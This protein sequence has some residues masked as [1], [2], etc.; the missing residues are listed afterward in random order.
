MRPTGQVIEGRYRVVRWVDKGGIGEVYEVEHLH[1]QRRCAFKEMLSHKV[2]EE[3][4]RARFARE[5][6][7]SSRVVHENIVEVLDAGVDERGVPWIAMEFL[8]G[9]N[10]QEALK[11]SGKFTTAA[12]VEVIDQVCAGLAA[13]HARDVIHCDLKPSNIFLAAPRR[14]GVPWTVTIL[15]FGIAKLLDTH[16]TGT[17][18]PVGTASYMAPEQY[19]ARAS[20][21]PTADLWALGLIA[22]ELLVGR[23]Y[24]LSNSHPSIMKEVVSDPLVTASQRVVEF[25][26]AP[27]VIP[28]GFDEWFS[29][30]VVRDPSKRFA[31]ADACRRAIRKALS[32]QSAASRAAL[33]ELDTEPAQPKAQDETGDA[34]PPPHPSRRSSPRLNAAG[35]ERKSGGST[36]PLSFRV[37]RRAAMFALGGLVAVLL[38]AF[39]ATNL[40]RGLRE[41]SGS[42]DAGQVALPSASAR[43]LQRLPTARTAGAVAEAGHSMAP[44]GDA[45]LETCNATEQPFQPCCAPNQ[46]PADARTPPID[47]LDLDRVYQLWCATTIAS[48]PSGNVCA[49]TE[50]RCNGAPRRAGE[51]QKCTVYLK[52]HGRGAWTVKEIGYVF[53]PHEADGTKLR[54]Q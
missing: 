3:K 42:I 32:E 44:V 18:Q 9:Q 2:Q 17:T 14:D 35:V 43:M 52:R 54:A 16:T 28:G 26:M 5:S 12:V 41:P 23:Q 6:R 15:D 47:E 40:R 53:G 24:W 50:K 21:E 49:H 25:G 39:W 30:C 38:S 46:R 33:G 4:W 8:R 27:D 10:L 31:S 29:Q 7:I 22:F 13:A 36:G 48:E 19:Q 20:I 1:T 45:L 11:S 34:T 37:G 51:C